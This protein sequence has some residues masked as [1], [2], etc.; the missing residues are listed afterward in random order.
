MA[1][2][3]KKTQRELYTEILDNPTLTEEQKEFL[4]G[5]IEALDKKTAS[6]KTTANQEQN[7]ELAEAVYEYMAEG[8][9]YTVTDL[10]KEVPA[11]QEIDPL[12]N[13]KTT[14]IVG[15]LVKDGRVDKSKEKGRTYF[16]KAVA[17]EVEGE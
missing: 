12:S 6:K 1:N 4:Q 3:T 16:Q 10:M 2:K 17:V 14:H 9:K 15:L 7:Q 11:L 5:R 13:Q 8:K